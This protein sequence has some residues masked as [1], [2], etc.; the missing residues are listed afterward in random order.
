MTARDEMLSLIQGRKPQYSLPQPFYVDQQFF[1]LDMELIWYRD[2]LFAGHDCELPKTGSYFTLQV[3]AYPIVVLRDK[4]GGIRAFHNSC[5]HRGSRV[6][7]QPKGTA[8]K[9]V[10]PLAPI[11]NSDIGKRKSGFFL[12]L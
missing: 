6:C 7:N 4:D 11:L 10:C 9:L 1:D 8:P 2:W 5:R 3:G 12:N